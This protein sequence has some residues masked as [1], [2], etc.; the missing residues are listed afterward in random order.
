MKMQRTLGLFL[1]HHSAPTIRMHQLCR[2]ACSCGPCGR[3]KVSSVAAIDADEDIWSTSGDPLQ[4]EIEPIFITTYTSPAAYFFSNV[5]AFY[6]VPDQTTGSSRRTFFDP[7]TCTDYLISPLAC[8]ISHRVLGI[9]DSCRDD[10]HGLMK[11]RSGLLVA[12]CGSACF[13]KVVWS[14]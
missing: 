14:R 12:L 3:F 1:D 10:C 4:L 11:T 8:E 13:R 6:I 7:A 2:P 9:S 5:H